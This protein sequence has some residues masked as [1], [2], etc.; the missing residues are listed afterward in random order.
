MASRPSRRSQR[1]NS[2]ANIAFSNLVR[3]ERRAASRA[4]NS[5][6]LSRSCQVVTKRRVA[7]MPR[8][9]PTG[10]RDLQRRS[11]AAATPHGA[12]E[13]LTML[14][15][16]AR[17]VI[18]RYPNGEVP[19]SNERRSAFRRPARPL[20]QEIGLEPSPTA[21]GGAVKPMKQRSAQV[22]RKTLSANGSHRC[23]SSS[24]SVKLS[25]R[26]TTHAMQE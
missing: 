16:G 21:S 15:T 20:P 14:T 5:A 9:C 12:L 24:T 3:T 10:A 23:R 22:T 11:V 8:R 2:D 18:P 25:D 13:S 4:A 19:V 26:N 6:L 17:R 1:C 7:R